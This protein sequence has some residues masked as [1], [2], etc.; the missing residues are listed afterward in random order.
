MRRAR[1]GHPAD[2]ARVDSERP[3]DALVHA[4]IAALWRAKPHQ[5]RKRLAQWHVV[6]LGLRRAAQVERRPVGLLPRRRGAKPL[7]AGHRKSVGTVH[8]VIITPC[9]IYDE[10]RNIFTENTFVI[11][12]LTACVII[13]STFIKR[14]MRMI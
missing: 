2:E 4:E 7:A 8:G 9:G 12:F 14:V 3:Q 6:D 13:L 1:R 11:A 10:S 5:A